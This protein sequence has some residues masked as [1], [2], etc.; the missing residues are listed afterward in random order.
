MGLAKARLSFAKILSIRLGG[1]SSGRFLAPDVINLVCDK[2]KPL[3]FE[4]FVGIVM[5]KY[6]KGIA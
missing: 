1:E 4:N 5:T 6:P 3:E 2:I